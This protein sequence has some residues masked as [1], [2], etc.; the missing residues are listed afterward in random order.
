MALGNTRKLGRRHKQCLNEI[1]GKLS[2]EIM[3]FSEHGSTTLPSLY[4][5][6]ALAV[7]AFGELFERTRTFPN[8]LSY[9]RTELKL[10][11]N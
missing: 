10:S 4:S 5:E 11:E 9:F 8:A 7:R 3:N 6:L 1:V 2:A